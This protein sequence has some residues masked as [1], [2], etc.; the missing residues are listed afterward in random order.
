MKVVRAGAECAAVHVD[1][2]PVAPTECRGRRRRR[3]VGEAP[4]THEQAGLAGDRGDPQHVRHA[5]GASHLGGGCLDG[6]CGQG[7]AR[8]QR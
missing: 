5:A 4:R 3:Q 1:A 2:M 6:G 7:E 8:E